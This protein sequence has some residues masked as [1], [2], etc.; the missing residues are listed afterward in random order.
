M[1]TQL[2]SIQSLVINANGEN[3]DKATLQTQID[4]FKDSIAKYVSSAQFNGLNFLDASST[5]DVKI[6][7]ALNRD[8][9][10]VV[11]TDTIDI[12]RKDLSQESGGSLADLAD[13]D[14]STSTDLG[15]DLTSITA[16]LKS[17]TQVAS[18]YGSVESQ[19]EKQSTFL[20]ALSDAMTAGVGTLVDADMEEASARLTALQTQ[21]QLGIQALS[22]ANQQPQTILN[23]FQ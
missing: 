14:V 20:G 6:V 4:T 1:V 2:Q 13:L 23:L 11:T 8:S 19:I 21:Q 16:M 18:Y 12:N 7:A 22:I 10:G 9:A 5:D 15:A 3:V 17:A